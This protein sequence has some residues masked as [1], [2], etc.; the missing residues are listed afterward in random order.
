MDGT[1]GLT[2]SH[3]VRS[4]ADLLVNGWTDRKIAGAVRD[5]ALHQLRRGWFIDSGEREKLWEEERHRAH[6]IAV[7]RD[8]RGPAVMSHSS[9]AV[10]WGLPLYGMR[11]T[12]VHMTTDAPHRISSSPDV[13]RHVSPL[14][15]DDVSVVGGIRCT[16]LARTVFDLI[17]ELPLEAAVAV[18]DAGERQMASRGREWDQDART[19]WRQGL[20]ERLERGAGVRGI[21][22]AR[23]VSVFADG[24]AE[25]PGESV[26]RLQLFR[27]GF[28]SPELQV[29]VDGPDG[30]AYFVDFGLRGLRAFGEF[31]GRQKYVDAALRSGKPVEQVVLEEKQRE[32]WIRG[33]THWRFARWDTS[34]IKTPRALALRLAAFGLSPS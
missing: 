5:G 15:V 33:T 22:Q 9:A 18:A 30:R 20:R 25:S 34:H 23:W 8:A 3:H 24:R 11:L 32:D 31:D 7:A 26:S 13:R 6:V 12:R 4:R 29:R 28:E 2:L 17:R 14:R 10:L 1:A 19:S 21:R 27:L 16:G